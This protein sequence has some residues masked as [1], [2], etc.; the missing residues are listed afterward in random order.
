MVTSLRFISSINRPNLKYT[1]IHSETKKHFSEV[2]TKT[3]LEYENSNGIIYCLSRKECDDYAV[4]LTK[5]GIKAVSYHAGFTNEERSD[6]QRK[7]TSN[8]VCLLYYIN[9]SPTHSDNIR[10]YHECDHKSTKC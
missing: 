2:T 3:V 4:H 6:R 5:S 7:W 1:I 8:E 9:N 10:L